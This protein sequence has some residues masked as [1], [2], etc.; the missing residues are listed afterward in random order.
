MDLS[1]V[2]YSNTDQ[3]KSAGH[4]DFYKVLRKRVN[5]YFKDNNISRH[6][7]ANM[8]VKSIFMISLYVV[9]FVLMLTYFESTGMILLMWFLYS[10]FTTMPTPV[11]NAVLFLFVCVFVCF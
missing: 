9:P 11:W 5:S 1:K 2:R 3:D 7:N 10:F 8:V 6:A 4:E